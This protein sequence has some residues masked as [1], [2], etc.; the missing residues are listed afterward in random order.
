M[1]SI[2]VRIPDELQ[3][4]LEQLSAEQHRSASDLVTESLRRY[5]ATEQFKAM[6]RMSVPLAEAQGYITDED[7][8]KATS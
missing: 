4:Q 2:N 5:I 6:R 1:G 7:I 3:R 8:F